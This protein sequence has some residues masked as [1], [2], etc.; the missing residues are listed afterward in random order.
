MHARPLACFCTIDPPNKART[1][2]LT[3]PQNGR[4]AHSEARFSVVGFLLMSTPFLCRRF[5]RRSAEPTKKLMKTTLS[6]ANATRIL[7][8]LLLFPSV[9]SGCGG[10]HH[11]AAR[12]GHLRFTVT[13]PQQGPSRVIPTA[14]QSL[15]VQVKQGTTVINSGV[16]ARPASTMTFPELPV[17]ALSVSVWAFA[18]TDGTGTPMAAAT[19]STTIVNNQ[20]SNVDVT[21]A[22]TID[23]LEVTPNPYVLGAGLSG[24][25][26]V[27][28]KDAGGAIVLIDPSALSFSS[29]AP[30]VVAVTSA[31]VATAGTS[32]GTATITI[33][34]ADS[35][36]TLSLP[37]NV[38]PAITVT[39]SA[40]TLTLRGTATFV[41]TVVGPANTAVAWT[42]QEGATG[43][44]ITSGGVYTAPTT[45]GTYHV[46][47]TSVAD[48]TAKAVAT[49]TVTSGGANVGVH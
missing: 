27:V 34:E 9:L 16:I 1:L 40:N 42:V 8:C 41:A 38:V 32:V 33:L 43:G 44:T 5:K 45:H 28:G 6:S 18:S 29:S 7:A 4:I 10:S 25:I 23:H 20:T 37:L 12:R 36:K 26:N 22:S 31:G 13:W 21:L 19:V 2:G 14:A 17:G 35:G 49:V 24:T 30:G 39:P 46:V 48:S 15:L 47:A 3:E 11:A